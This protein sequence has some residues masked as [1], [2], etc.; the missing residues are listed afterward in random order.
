MSERVIVSAART[1]ALTRR[2]HCAAIPYTPAEIAEE[3]RRAAEA[4]AAIVHIHARSDDGS[5]TW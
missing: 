3:A 5:P 4:G 1:G 2:E